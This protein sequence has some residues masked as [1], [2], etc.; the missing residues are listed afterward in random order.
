MKLICMRNGNMCLDVK[1]KPF[2][3]LSKQCNNNMLNNV[4]SQKAIAQL[5]KRR[6]CTVFHEIMSLKLH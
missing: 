6:I 1:N 4:G 5:S 2:D 3:W